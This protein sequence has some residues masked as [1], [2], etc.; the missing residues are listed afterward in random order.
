MEKIG[1]LDILIIRNNNTLKATV[2]KKKHIT[3]FI[4]IGNLSRQHLGN[5]ARYGQ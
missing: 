4:Y 5:V 3:E 2:H 1:F